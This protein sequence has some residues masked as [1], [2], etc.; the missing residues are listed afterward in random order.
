MSEILL[1]EMDSILTGVVKPEVCSDAP[2]SFLLVDEQENLQVHDEA[3]F[4]EK[5]GCADVAGVKV[6]SIFGNTGDG[7]SHTLNHIL[8]SGE[9]VFYTSKSPSSCTVGVWAAYNPALSLVALDTEGLLGAA[10][11]QN[12]RMRLLLKVLAVSDIVIYRTRAERLHNDM[13]HFLSSASVAYLKHF[14]QELRA[15]ST[16]C[17]LDVPLSSLGPAVIVFQETTHTQLLGHDSGQSDM[18]LQKRFHD[19]GL[20]T[21]AFS[22][23]QYVGTQTITP[24]TDYNRLL[25]AVRQQVRNT[26]TR[27]PRQPGIVFHALEALSERFCGELSDDKMTLYSFFPDEYFTCSSVCLS[28]NL[29][30]NKVRASTNSG[31][32]RKKAMLS[33]ELKQEIIKKHERGV[34]VS[35]LAK[36]Y[37]RN[38]ST[39]STIIKQ[40]E[41]IKAVR[42]SKGITI[43]SK[44]RS[45]TLDDMERLLLIW[46]KD[47]EIAGDT[48]TETIICDKASTIFCD[49]KASG[50][51]VD[52]GKSSTD[53]TT[54][55]FKASRGWFE[56]FKKRAGIHS[57]VRHG[58]PSSSDTKAANQFIKEFENILNEE[59]YVTQQVFNCDET[60]LFWKKMPR[61]TYITAEEKKMPGHKPM[62]DRLTL[63]LCANASGDCKIKP[64]LVY[65][66]ENPRAFKAHKVNKDLLQVFWRANAKAWVTRLI[67]VEWVNQVFGP[68]VKKYLQENNLPLKC[69]LCLDKAPAHPPGLEDDIF[70]EFKFIKVLYLPPNTTPILQPMGQQVISNFK[71][72]YTKYLFK[73][74]FDVTQ[75]ANLTLLKYW[76]RHFNIVHC[77][78]IIGQAWEGVTRLTLN[79]AWKKLWPDAVAPR[80]FEGCEPVPHPEP[81][82]EEI[83]SIGKSMGLDVDEDDITELVEEHHEELTTDEL[84]ELEAMQKSQIHAQLSETEEDVEDVI[85]TAEIKRMLGYHQQVVDFVEKHHPQK[86]QG[87]GGES[88]CHYGSIA[89]CVRECARFALF[90]PGPHQEKRPCLVPLAIKAVAAAPLRQAYSRTALIRQRHVQQQLGGG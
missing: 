4:V 35:D 81:D 57:V 61:R 31:E 41:A 36:E 20:G 40:K 12:Q 7:K 14:S 11:N 68:A 71:K 46:I 60:G 76:R 26:H 6:L 44:R 39:I 83:V 42:P 66:S 1:K 45:P 18:Q 90:S 9:S 73:Q 67:F 19:L 21:E 38:M 70:D 79:S 25:D 22:S 29:G 10:A 88:Y 47:K 34:R 30:S 80:D 55:K 3:E 32:K 27:S 72:L 56:K 33:L 49:L 59:G 50:S 2:R 85:S 15:L 69:L 65:H 37:G 82:V 89:P 53:P 8:F 74:C 16:R 77:L 64:L 84:K 23:V 86:L 24:P 54:E 62:K 58:D 63:A 13:F 43:I 78:K 52:A 75:S 51:G 17:G 48:I 28:C 5:L 87:N